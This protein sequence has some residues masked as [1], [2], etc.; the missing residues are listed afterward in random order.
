MHADPDLRSH[1]VHLNGSVFDVVGVTPPGFSGELVGTPTDLWM[2]FAAV[3][4]VVP[5]IP[6]GT[7]GFV[8][9]VIA[10]LA[11]GV[12][13]EHAREA[14]NVIAAG[15]RAAYPGNLDAPLTIELMVRHST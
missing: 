12:S 7:G 13:L 5:E 8:V 11:P 2:P 1:T 15:Y 10:R 14:M 9:R 3:N 4:K 6:S